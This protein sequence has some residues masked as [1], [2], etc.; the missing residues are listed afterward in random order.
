MPIIDYNNLNIKKRVIDMRLLFTSAMIFFILFSVDIFPQVRGVKSELEPSW[1]YIGKAKRN[2]NDGRIGEAIYM[3]QGIILREPDNADAH[4]LL[5][6]TYDKEAE[7]AATQGGQ[8]SYRLAIT[9]Y[10]KSIE[11]SKN[12]T[13][14]AN[15]IDSYFRL[16]S[17]Y[18]KLL[19]DTAFAETE[20]KI[21][22]IVGDTTS[23]DTK[24]RIHFRL[25]EF[26]AKYG[27]DNTAIENYKK[28]Y[29]YKY[30]KK[31]SLFR[32]SLLYRKRRDYA[33]EKE[34]LTLA[35]GY[36]FEFDEPVN[37]EVNKIIEARLEQLSNI[38]T[39]PKFY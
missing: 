19:D 7:N 16:L 10:K 24:G 8:A 22:A 31:L 12:L 36:N 28:S 26:Y 6:L 2:I 29:E 38:R 30:R 25:G 35:S 21:L 18:E 20:K 11:Y 15:E 34:I 39:K 27:Q 9:H 33:K 1:V 5:G 23:I 32:M 4:Y 17:I 13:I 3:L 14:P 37:I